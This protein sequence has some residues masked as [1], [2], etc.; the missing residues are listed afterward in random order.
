MRVNNKIEYLVAVIYSII[1]FFIP[2][3]RFRNSEFRDKEVYL[4]YVYYGNN[5]LTYKS[6]D[7][8]FSIS[9]YLLFPI[10]I[11]FFTSL[12]NSS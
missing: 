1:Y 7:S 3:E 12:S 9:A 2:W 11:P 5:I 8:F 4:D 10:R 6:F